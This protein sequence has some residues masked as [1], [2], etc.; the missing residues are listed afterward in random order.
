MKR[1]RPGEHL[2]PGGKPGRP[3]SN[4]AMLELLRGMRRE[5]GEPWSDRQGNS[6]VPHGLPIQFSRLGGRADL[7]PTRGNR[8]GR[9]SA[10]LPGQQATVALC[11]CALAGLRWGG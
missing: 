7:L 3:L 1:A 9:S 6:E 10:R 2:F 4:M 8:D 5:D 11:V